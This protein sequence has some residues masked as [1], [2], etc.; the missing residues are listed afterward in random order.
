MNE[1]LQYFF[2]LLIVTGIGTLCFAAV[3]YFMIHVI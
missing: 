2:E 1:R 3:T